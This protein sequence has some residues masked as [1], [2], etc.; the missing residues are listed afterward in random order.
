MA[1]ELFNQAG[2]ARNND[3]TEEAVTLYQ[4][5]RQQ[6][7]L[8]NDQ[9]RA[10]DCTHMIGVAYSQVNRYPEATRYLMIAE[11]EFRRLN[12]PMRLGAVLRDRGSVVAHQG[13]L[14]V[15]KHLLRRSIMVLRSTEFLGHL[16]VSRIKLGEVYVREGKYP[17]ARRLI[18]RGIADTEQ[19]PDLWFQSTGYFNLA[20][21]LKEQGHNLKANQALD[22]AVEILDKMAGPN[23][24]LSR[25]QQIAE[26]RQ[27]LQ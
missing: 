21:L 3:Q 8:E 10:A 1:V 24:Y 6:A 11:D 19:S 17:Q 25:R 12:N 22:K 9:L 16:G 13:N 2:I 18:K 4:Q 26:L 5:A 20:W 15:A 27:E 23:E 7:L 14:L